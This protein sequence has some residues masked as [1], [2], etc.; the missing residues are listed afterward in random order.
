MEQLIEMETASQAWQGL[1]QSENTNVK[2]IQKSD[3][4]AIVEM[5]VEGIPTYLGEVRHFKSNTYLKENMP[6]ELSIAWTKM[7]SGKELPT[8][9][10]PC[11]SL[12]IVTQ[13]TGRSTGDTEVALKA[14]DVVFIPPWN[15][16]G[17]KGTG[18]E[19]FTA[20]SIQFQESGIF[21]SEENP[22]TTYFDRESIPLEERQLKIFSREDLESIHKVV[23]AGEEKNLGTL[24]NFSSSQFLKETLPSYFSCS[25]VHLS[26]TEVLE[27]HVHATDSMIIVAEGE[28]SVS[29]NLNC[30]FKEGEIVYVPAGNEHGF[31]G[32]GENGF[33]ALSIQFEEVGLYEDKN[34]P[35]VRFIQRENDR[36]SYEN[37]IALNE[38]FGQEFQK[39]PIFQI[40]TEELNIDPTKKAKLLDCLQVMSNSFQRLMYSR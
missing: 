22:E 10:H 8:H 14:G 3:M 4:E 11:A 18:D 16:H 6:Q 20:L 21:S 25:W 35:L 13:G 31:Q 7:P 12:I 19:G 1:N 32:R 17:F 30:S 15:L 24:K 28:G 29:G 34:D 39:N 40:S 26:N 9:F 38:R 27:D 5:M 33:W 37:F 23:V 2:L 36:I